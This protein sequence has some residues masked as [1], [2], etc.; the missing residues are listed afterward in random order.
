MVSRSR[1][2][3]SGDAQITLV[4]AELEEVQSL[5]IFGATFYSKLTLETHRREVVSKAA[6]SLVVAFMAEKLFD[7]PRVSKSYF[8]AYILPNLE[9]PRVDVILCLNVDVVCGVSFEF[10]G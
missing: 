2:Y 9:C 10:A 5:C 3:A 7:C 1:I 6:R 8:N 4:G